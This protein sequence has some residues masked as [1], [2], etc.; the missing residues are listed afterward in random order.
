MDDSILTTILTLGVSVKVPVA[1]VADCHKP[2]DAD[3]IEGR[4]CFPIFGNIQEHSSVLDLSRRFRT[5][6]KVARRRGTRT[7]LR[8]ALDKGNTIP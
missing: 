4:R 1:L 3:E 6:V 7:R 5:E 8:G 2:M